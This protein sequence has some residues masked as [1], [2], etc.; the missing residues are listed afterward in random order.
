MPVQ[1]LHMSDLSAGRDLSTD[2]IKPAS[3]MLP[4]LTQ[5]LSVWKP[6]KSTNLKTIQD[7]MFTHQ[8]LVQGQFCA[9]CGKARSRR[10]Q[11]NH[12]VAIGHIPEPGVCSR[13]NCIRAQSARQEESPAQ[14]LVVEVHHYY[15]NGHGFEAAAHPIYTPEMP[16][17]TSLAGRAKVTGDMHHRPLSQRCTGQLSP[18]R[19]ESLPPVNRSTKPSLHYG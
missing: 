6:D 14:A 12:P 3:A 2:A 11:L 7:Q 19:E 13:P 5:K 9:L 18:I 1:L 8:S 15:H 17:E 10:Y 16:R 4:P